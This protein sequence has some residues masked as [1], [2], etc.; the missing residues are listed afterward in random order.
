M[1]YG[2][3]PTR[4]TVWL[5]HTFDMNEAADIVWDALE[6]A[7]YLDDDDDT[8]VRDAFSNLMMTLYVQSGYSDDSDDPWA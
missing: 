4:H 3:D 6:N 1:S 7:G 2:K 8:K 5:P